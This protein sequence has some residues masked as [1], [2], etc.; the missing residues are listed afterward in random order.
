MRAGEGTAHW[1]GAGVLMGKKGVEHGIRE[2]VGKNRRL[3]LSA[4]FL[5]I[6]WL[7][8]LIFVR[9]LS[10]NRP[11]IVSVLRLF[12]VVAF[13]FLLLAVFEWSAKFGSR[14]AGRDAFLLLANT[15]WRD[16]FQAFSE[17]W[18]M[19]K[20]EIATLLFGYVLLRGGQL[21]ADIENRRMTWPRQVFVVAF[22]DMG[23]VVFGNGGTGKT[24]LIDLLYHRYVQS[25]FSLLSDRRTQELGGEEMLG[26]FYEGKVVLGGPI[27][28]YVVT[29]G[30]RTLQVGFE[31]KMVDLPGQAWR[32]VFQETG[33]GDAYSAWTPHIYD[34]L[35]C[36]EALFVNVMTNGYGAAIVRQAVFDA[37]GE[38][39]DEYRAHVKQLEKDALDYLVG[40]IATRLRSGP[41]RCRRLY[42]VNMINMAGFW[43][44]DRVNT[45]KQYRE[46][47]RPTWSA[48]EAIGRN[49]RI[50]LK[51]WPYVPVSLKFDD[52]KAPRRA[53]SGGAIFSVDRDSRRDVLNV[54]ARNLQ[55]IEGLLYGD[56]E[57][58][59]KEAEVEE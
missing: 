49:H 23:S 34:L 58:P 45:E 32:Y 55:F 8:D 46:N 19:R 15:T 27:T 36:R 54:T 6:A 56:I 14:A 43:W 20:S 33:R 5:P 17:T 30:S 35:N 10:P 16:I 48:L 22:A 4:A 59:A 31:R 12:A 18:T 21:G 11:W 53:A 28:P 37:W 44:P 3:V 9:L 7:V 1:C 38:R 24:T 57:E 41:V 39:G 52:F 26:K 29:G 50:A 13:A 47:L 40:Q 25:R 2:F 51:Y 42:F